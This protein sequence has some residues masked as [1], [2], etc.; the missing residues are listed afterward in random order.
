MERAAA[1]ASFCAM[2]MLTAMAQTG[3]VE[4][5]KVHGKSLEGNL[6]GDAPERDVS[7]YLPPSYAKEK[8]RRYPVLY[9]LHGFTDSDAKWY[10]VTKHWINLP[11]V[12]NR[13]FAAPGAREFIVVTPNAYTR[14]GGSMY[15]SSVTTGDWE[16]YV[17]KELVE[18]VDRRYR[19]LAR[20]ESRGL[21]GHSMGGYGA[22]RIGMK[23]AQVFSSLY[24]LNP[25]CLGA[26][27]A[28]PQGP[29]A[30]WVA[31]A[32][33]IRPEEVEKA[34]FM[35]KATLA[36]GAAWS[37][38]PKNPPYFLDL[39][40]K[41]GQWQPEVAAKW[42]ANAPLAMVDQHVFGLKAMK[43]I[44]LDAGTQEGSITATTRQMHE[45]LERYGIAHAFEIYEGNH[46]NRVG[47]RIEKVMAP[48]FGKHLE[49]AAGSIK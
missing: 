12:L 41:S 39:T 35:V 34:T 48:F 27:L 24:A 20:K 36:S 2:S 45:V 43:G 17:A 32:E 14:F 37:P 7:V 44:G 15:S 30:E 9:F 28:R 19:T 46:T 42:A 22:L 40:M 4:R 25:C 38:N 1:L 23:N 29:G 47:E 21:A 11:E 8:N 31:Q 6:S 10:G 5:V 3:T 49:A 26:N 18:F 16:T 33:S 13:A